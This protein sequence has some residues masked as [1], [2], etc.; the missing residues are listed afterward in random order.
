V[1]CSARSILLSF[2]LAVLSQS[3]FAQETVNNAS[4]TGRVTDATGAV[5]GNAAV[6]AREVSTNV[7]RSTVTS[8]TGRF[9]F[10]YLPVGEYEITIHQPGFTDA[11]RTVKLTIGAAF[12]LPV[13]LEVGSAQSVV[14]INAEAPLLEADRSQ[15]A[16]TISQTEVQNLPF[17]GRNFLDLAL[18]V[19]GV[20]PTN[21]AANQLFAETSAVAGQGI[22]VS[23]QRNFSNSFIVDGLS[24]NDDAA[25]LVQTSFGLGV[26]REMQVVTSGGQA[27][28]GRAIGG[29][30]NF[31]SK[32][33]ANDLH[34][35]LYGFLRNQRLNAD[36]ALSGTDLPLTQAQYGAS[37][38]GPIVHNRTFYFGNFEQRQLNQDGIITITSANAAAINTVLQ[39]TRYKGQ[40]LAIS[41]HTP[42]TLYSNPV[43]STNFFLKLDHR[44]NDRDQLSARYSLYHVSSQNSRGAGGLNY[45]SAAAGLE[46]LDQTVA[47]SN[48]ATLTPLT[49]NETRGQFTNSNLKAPVND[50]V[51]PAVSISGIA[52]FGTLSA[53]PT[54]RYDRLYELV[55]NL[56]HQAGSH[57]LRVGADFLFNDL[58]I[59]YPQSIRGSY[60]FSSL[61]NFQKG[62]YSTFTQSFGNYV[63]PQTNPNIGFYGQDE[64]KPLPSLTL[65]LGLRYDL[66]FL[67]TINT[68]KNNFSPRFGFAWSPFQNHGTV[69]RGSFG[70]FYDRVP[71]R[72]LSNAIESNNNTT[73]IGPSTFTTLALSY[74]QA[75][76]PVFPAIASGYTATT[77]PAN[78][79]LSLSTMNPNL[80]NAYSEQA[81]LEI[82][83]QITPTSNLAISY[84]HLR[85]LHLLISVNLNTPA[86][87]ASQPAS[88][89]Q[90]PVVDPVNLC[91]PNNA[92]AN[93]KQYASSAD[94]Y[95]DGLSVSYVQR[96]IRW[97]S[98][99]VSYTWS[100]ALDNVSEFFFSSPLNNFNLA[101]DRSR[102]DD[103]QR[104]R[105][106][107][108]ATLHSS[109]GPASTFTSKLTHGFLLSGI[110]QY[111]SAFPFNVTTGSNSI[112]T[113][114]LRPCAP[115][116]VLTPNAAKTCANVLPGTVIGRNAAI[117]FDAF[118][119][120]TRLSR[121]IPLGE[122]FKLEGI[123]EAFN[124]LNHRNNQIPNTTFGTG[125]YPTAPSAT[126][127]QP[128]AVGDPRNI[129]LA[130]RL[131]F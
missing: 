30:I 71:L 19:P 106:V 27:E 89:P 62:V 8:P 69:V 53:S 93:N 125:V 58:T 17:N 121:T 82:D 75:G 124:T 10:P 50:P 88:G 87:Y 95:Y 29:Y 12:D 113:T 70:L 119:L 94:S 37:L 57:A 122:R 21:T 108:N 55:D 112:Q 60:A 111:Y 96:P 52:S 73:I 126:Y 115:G 5:V 109:M 11:R 4:L 98:Y 64:W 86:C 107:F 129:Q 63:V 110:L 7:T 38:G 46:D 26:I 114:A 3:V 44:I 43:H 31:I 76:A 84:Q 61:S 118:T 59:T 80:Q 78:I 20:S 15:V 128:T 2:V 130:L 97:G 103:D 40:Q 41:S 65:N 102:S 49:I 34:G 22:S 117:G 104:H 45:T 91:R 68:D 16:G 42:A 123:A 18:L 33:G 85:G 1:N 100:K 13:T 67:Q 56:S 127:G 25:G 99:R 92:Y 14:D 83:Q 116:Y 101:M 79:K 32:S 28:F 23:S 54:A 77:L 47:V 35:D 90:Y 120:N 74:G 39:N 131:S 66:Q 72:A 48:I 6:V 51:G 81:S 24:A 9:R 105:L 36:N